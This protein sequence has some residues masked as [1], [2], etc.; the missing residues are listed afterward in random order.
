[1]GLYLQMCNRSNR[2]DVH[3]RLRHM[4]RQSATGDKPANVI[5][6]E[7]W[8]ATKSACDL[9]ASIRN[10]G[11]LIPVVGTWEPGFPDHPEH[12]GSPIPCDRVLNHATV[13]DSNQQPEKER[14]VN[15]TTLGNERL[16]EF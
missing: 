5:D 13:R 2:D 16:R 4:V 8:N 7:L 15:S 12:N 1:M 9:A 14:P 6:S 10:R 3:A 11:R